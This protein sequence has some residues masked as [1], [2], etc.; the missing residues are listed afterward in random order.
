MPKRRR[1]RRIVARILIALG[2]VIAAL[3]IASVPLYVLPGDQNARAADVVVVIGPPTDAQ[4]ELAAEIIDAGQADALLVSITVP[5][6]GPPQDTGWAK[7]ERPSWASGSGSTR[8][9]EELCREPGARAFGVT[10][11]CA[12]P[13]PFTT[14]GE[15]QWLAERMEAHD[16]D[17]AIV[18]TVTPHVTRTRMLMGRCIPSGVQVLGVDDALTV[19]E[20]LWQFAY[21]S[22]GFV[23]AI[24]E[25]GC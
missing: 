6:T 17:T 15:A 23:K 10:L 4:M 22:G 7:P 21:Q 1:A 8:I 16:W 12:Q 3:A 25:P 20:W 24:V 19:G 11:E 18:S 9:A 13:E 5:S 14:Q 2:A